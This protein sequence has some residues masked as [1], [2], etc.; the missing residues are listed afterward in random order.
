MNK[1]VIVGNG[2]DLAHGLPTSYSDFLSDFWSTL[3]IGTKHNI[4]KEF[5]TLN[6]LYFQ[7]LNYDEKPITDFKTLKENLAGYCRDDH[8]RY[9]DNPVIAKT[10]DGK[11]I[12]KF[13]NSFF[14][15]INQKQSIQNWV[16]IE[17]EYYLILKE[18]VIRKKSLAIIDLNRE[19]TQ[20]QDLLLNYLMKKVS[21]LWN[22]DEFDKTNHQQR[23]VISKLFAPYR[24]IDFNQKFLEEF[25][26]TNDK[27][28]L[29]SFYSRAREDIKHFRINVLTFNYTDSVSQYI[30]ENIG[31]SWKD[32]LIHIHGNLFESTRIVF[33]YGDEMDEDYNRIENLN[34]NEFLKNFKSFAYA[35]TRDYSRLFNYINSGK[36]QVIIL[37]H[38]C[39]LSDRTLLNTVFEHENC[40][41]IKVYYYKKDRMDNYTD[42]VQN[43]SRHFKDKQ[44]MRRK[45][46]NKE[47]CKPLPQGVRF[48]TKP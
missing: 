12:F 2:F 23:L 32:S 29:Q 21:N 30:F 41:S 42:L 20:V 4:H 24:N 14:E 1:L 34:D 45:V 7:Y 5:L 47:L 31:D 43:I 18:E 37:G 10:I 22:F 17:N 15:H 26:E 48:K 40:R 3:T 8:H 19:F 38:S 13:Q 33:G 16:D 39:G 25:Q 46:V 35:Q 11:T 9:Q 36:F 6:P 28:E 44:L 27:Y